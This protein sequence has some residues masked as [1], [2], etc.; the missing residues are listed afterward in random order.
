MTYAEFPQKFVW[1]SKLREW[2]P[3]KKAF[4]I[5]R[6]YYVPPGCGESYYM[7]CLLNHIRGVTCHEDLRTINGVL[8]NSYRETCYALG[9]L[10]DDKEFVDGFTEA[11]DFA[12][13]FALRILFVILLWSESM[14]RPEFVW[15]KCWIYMAEDIQY[16]LRKMYQHPGFVM[17]NEQLHM[18]ALAEIEMLL[19]RRGKSLRDYPP[20]PCPTSSS[21]LLPENRLVQ[22]ELQYDRQAMHEE[23]NT[24]L[25]GLTSE[26]RI[27]YEKIIN[28]VETECGGMYFVY[29]YGGTGKTFVW[30]TLSAAL[31]SKGDIVLNVASSGIA[32]LLLPG[33]R[34]AH[35]WFAIPI[36]LN[37]DSTCNIKQGSPLA[38]LIAKCK[39]IIWDEAPMLHKYCFEA[40][41]RSMRDILRFTNPNSLNLPFGGKTIVLG[42]DFRQVLPVIPQGSRQDVVNATINSS[43]LW[44]ECTVL[45]LTKNMRLQNV[46]SP[47]ESYDLKLF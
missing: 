7:R 36:S 26:Q 8:Y 23:H 3:R 40:L 22:E 31:R 4:A 39:L 43:Y 42:G 38:M 5:G 6:I 37:E 34:T 24:L 30:R 9:L 20:M 12:T 14:S 10:D 11:S 15:E 32:S 27:V 46:N 45:R 33:G 21:T 41:D 28:S 25:Q 1:K 18:A 19:H 29:G 2:M 35:S 13:A 16:K 47:T 44:G 17:D